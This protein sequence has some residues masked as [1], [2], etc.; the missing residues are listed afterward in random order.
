M[1]PKKQLLD[2]VET[3][4]EP[5]LVMVKTNDF[6]DIEKFYGFKLSQNIAEKFADELFELMPKHLDFNKFLNL[7]NGEYIFAQ[8]I[9]VDSNEY[10]DSL[11]DELKDLQKSVNTLKIDVGE[12]DYDISV[13]ISIASGKECVENV[14][15]GV[16]ALE[17][18]KQDVIVANNLAKKEQEKAQNNLKVLK[19]IKRALQN[20]NIISHFQP[21]V[22]NKTLDIVKY[23]SL[24]RLI[25]EDNNVILPFSFLDNI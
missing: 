12:I 6:S 5:L 23:E 15:Y 1:S 20:S 7:G 13:V 9:G 17:E 8:D 24:V 21:I 16:K 14:F 11:V 25:D 10:M 19:M 4:S 18:N 22:S 2:F 3:A